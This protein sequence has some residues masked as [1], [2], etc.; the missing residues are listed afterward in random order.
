[1]LFEQAVYEY[2]DDKQFGRKAVRPN[3]MEGYLSAIRCHL[4]PKWSGREVESITSAELQSS[5]AMNSTLLGPF[6]LILFTDYKLTL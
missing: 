2:V 1:M 6:R 5:F 4:L 3:T